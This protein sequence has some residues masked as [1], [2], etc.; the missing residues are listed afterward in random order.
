M[1][2]FQSKGKKLFVVGGI[3]RDYLTG[4][5]PKDFDLSY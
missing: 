4:D 1:K 5:K 3:V 2:L